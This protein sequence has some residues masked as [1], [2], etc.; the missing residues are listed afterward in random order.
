MDRLAVRAERWVRS[1]E[2]HRCAIVD[3]LPSAEGGRAFR[4]Q[5][6]DIDAPATHYLFRMGTFLWNLPPEADLADFLQGA[7]QRLNADSRVVEIAPFSFSELMEDIEVFYPAGSVSFDET[8]FGADAFDVRTFTPALRFAIQVPLKNQPA[9]DGVHDVPSEKYWVAW[10]GCTAAVLWAQPDNNIPLAGGHIALDVLENAAK[11]SA[12]SLINQACSPGCK[13]LFMH[14][15]MVISLTGETKLEE[16]TYL[17]VFSSNR[18]G[19]DSFDV[20]VPSVDDELD[21]LT[22]LSLTLMGTADHFASMKSTGARLLSVE[23]AARSELSHAS[24]HQY[25]QSQLATLPLGRRILGSWKRRGSRREMRHLVAGLLLSLANMEMLLRL[26]QDDRQEFEVAAGSAGESI[27]FDADMRRDIA[28]IEN[29]KL[30]HLESGVEQLGN[31]LNNSALAVATAGG[32]LAGG[33]AG[34]IL[35]AIAAIIGA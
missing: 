26:W 32:A 30:E 6:L 8:L 35:G 15:T 24:L 29:L 23:R 28:R 13:N 5:S 11:T 14:S 12:S 34:G 20:V 33:V 3:L 2:G 7:I 21:A 22:W 19:P 18:S 17:K 4:E 25:E 16:S 1:E 31:S 9:R 10:N 27:I